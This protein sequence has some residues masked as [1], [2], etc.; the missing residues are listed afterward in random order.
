MG[1]PKVVLVI[2]GP[3]PDNYLALL[4]A[5]SQFMCYELVAVIMTGRPV[6]AV[7]S[8]PAHVYNPH[9]SRAVRRDNAL[10]AKGI[11]MRH[12]G[13]NV[14]VF[15]GGM[16]TYSTVPHHM[17][18]HERVTDVFDDAHAGHVLA[19][20]LEDAILYLAS[21]EDVVHVICGGPLT[22][23]S[24]LMSHPLLMG[25]LGIATAQLGMFG[26]NSRVQTN[27]GG[28]RQFNALADPKAA[29]DVLMRYPNAFYMIP[30][31]ITK[32]PE[33]GFRSA[34]DFES[35]SSSSAATELAAMYRM[36]WPH[37][38]A[39]MRNSEG[40]VGIPAHVHDFHPAELMHY[41]LLESPMHHMSFS[42]GGRD[43]VGRYSLSP[44]GIEHVPHQEHEIDRWGEIDLGPMQE[45]MPLRF[46]T[47]G[48]E[49]SQHRS[50]LSAVLN[51]IYTNAP[52]PA[53]V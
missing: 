10:H 19:G 9:A 52:L 28:R 8:L 2:D 40:G 43:Q 50:I 16:A 29:W 6:S 3:D 17:H 5:L 27:A 7:T 53:F 34:D 30:T 33:L 23:V 44:V 38:W 21:L 12:G 46:V 51:N 37:M 45:N 24:R 32:D 18:I 47:D 31:D 1:R 11:L 39:K 25:R 15:T 14:P 36:A 22:D 49:N 20:E 48:C 35:L 13:E 4:A 26:F 42:R 41:L